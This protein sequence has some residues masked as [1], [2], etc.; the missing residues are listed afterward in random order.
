MTSY[1]PAV[2]ESIAS[3]PAAIK[4]CKTDGCGRKHKAY[5]FCQICYHRERAAGRINLRP[6]TRT[7]SNDWCDRPHS[8][9]GF[10]KQCY[11]R[12]AKAGDWSRCL[13]VAGRAALERADVDPIAVQRLIDGD[14]PERTTLGEREAAVRALHAL[15]LTDRQI[16]ER[17][18]WPRVQQ[19]RKRLG[20]PLIR[21][22]KSRG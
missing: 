3:A 19:M 8:G 21:D 22:V 2:D 4:G 7:C 20:L 6:G 11:A 14:P 13:K 10:C 5:G 9:R 12:G 15:G 1:L 17:M 18:R 16:A